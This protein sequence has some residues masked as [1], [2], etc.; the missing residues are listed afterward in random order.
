MAKAGHRLVDQ[1][2]AGPLVERVGEAVPPCIG[3]SQLVRRDGRAVEKESM[4]RGK[5]GSDGGTLEPMD[6]GRCEGLW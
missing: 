3:K 5:K 1:Q 2:S 6:E 4:K